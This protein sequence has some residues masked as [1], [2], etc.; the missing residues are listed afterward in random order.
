VWAWRVVEEVGARRVLPSKASSYGLLGPEPSLEIGAS[1]A[2]NA[3]GAFTAIASLSSCAFLRRREERDRGDGRRVWADALRQRPPSLTGG[4]PP[5]L[6]PCPN[7][8]A[9]DDGLSAVDE[10]GELLGLDGL[11]QI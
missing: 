3:A 8:W 4:R 1:P 11:L 10:R 2:L 6:R 5:S 9:R 7:W